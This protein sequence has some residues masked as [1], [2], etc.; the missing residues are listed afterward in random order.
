MPE[1]EGRPTYKTGTIVK[2][3]PILRFSEKGTA[4]TR[5]SIKVKPRKTEENP[6]PEDQFYVVSAFKT[7]AEN[8]CQCLRKGDRVLV[9][10]L[11]SVK[12]REYNSKTYSDKVIVAESIGAEI[13]FNG[14]DVHRTA[15]S[16]PAAA[17]PA[18]DESPF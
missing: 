13:T 11:G 2:E 14:V 9:A 5:F 17:Q 6:N 3:D 8:I 4:W 18:L 12:T 16:S 10:G 15:R 7:L 1:T